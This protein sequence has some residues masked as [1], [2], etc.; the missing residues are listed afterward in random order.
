MNSAGLNSYQHE[1]WSLCRVPYRL[2][3]SPW[4]VSNLNFITN[5][6][7]TLSL[8][9]EHVIKFA[10][11]SFLKAYLN[12]QTRVRSPLVLMWE[13]N[14]QMPHCALIY[15]I[16]TLT[17]GDHIRLMSGSNCLVASLHLPPHNAAAMYFIRRPAKKSRAKNTDP[18]L[19]GRW[20]ILSGPKLI[21]RRTCKKMTTL[22]ESVIE[23]NLKIRWYARHIKWPVLKN[24]LS[25][26]APNFHRDDEVNSSLMTPV[27]L[28]ILKG[29]LW[30]QFG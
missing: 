27:L 14:P 25:D 20:L 26:L 30:G 4:A 22:S 1:Y 28:F 19:Y 5:T 13:R 7:E 11:T 10:Q 17:R 2:V 24:V 21:R 23:D 15:S 29:L 9:I 8:Y 16:N 18:L 3:R 6:L 12:K